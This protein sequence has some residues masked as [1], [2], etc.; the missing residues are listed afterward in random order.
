MQEATSRKKQNLYRFMGV[1]SVFAALILTVADY[2]LEFHKE[3]GLSSSIVEPAWLEMAPW[4]FS[5]SIYL[6]M[7][8]IPF[9]LLGFWLLYK[10]VSKTN[11]TLALILFVLFSYGV[12]MGSPFIHGVMGLNSVIYAFLF[13]NGVSHE[14]LVNLIEGTL[15]P[16]I[17]PVFLVHYLI[18]WVAAPLLLFFHIIRDKSVF[19]RWTAFLN[20]FVFLLIGVVG[21]KLYP[22]LFAYLAPGAINKGNAAM[23]ALVAIRMW[24][25]E[26]KN[27]KLA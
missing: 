25:G 26:S 2:L 18:T 5:L 8:M 3:Y 13:D 17:L 23:F 6:C 7:F 4:R 24:N 20:P 1:S 16:T 21:L 12:V 14:L 27:S 9:Y 19:R 11:K 22:Q 10:V 15:F